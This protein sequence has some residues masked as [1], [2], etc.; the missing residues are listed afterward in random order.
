MLPSLSAHHHGLMQNWFVQV[1]AEASRVIMISGHG[2]IPSRHTPR[3]RPARLEL[4]ARCQELLLVLL[5]VL[6]TN[7]TSLVFRL[8]CNRSS[9]LFESMP[10]DGKHPLAAGGTEQ[11]P[12]GVQERSSLSTSQLPALFASPG[13]SPLALSS[14]GDVAAASSH[15]GATGTPIASN[16]TSDGKMASI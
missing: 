5:L 10:C 4:P 12:P 9:G 13:P 1:P 8:A 16:S 14:V 11:R 6:R 2:T 3:S 15:H 7:S